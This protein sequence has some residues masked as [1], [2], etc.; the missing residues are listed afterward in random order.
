LFKTKCLVSAKRSKTRDWLDL[1]VLLH[2][3][4][5]SIR[6]FWQAFQEAGVP[7]DCARSLS[8]LCSGVPQRDDEG[9]AHLLAN[10]PTLE[11]MK[12]YFIEQRNLLEIEI[13]A[14]ALRQRHPGDSDTQRSK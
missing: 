4:G 9:Y 12:T 7:M 2:D 1:Y 14:D 6:E 5:F 8:R 11:Q 13:A 10:P 3:H